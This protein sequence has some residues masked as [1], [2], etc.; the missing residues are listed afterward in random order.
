MSQFTL[1]AT[2]EG[3]RFITAF[4]PGHGAE[5]ANSDHP[6]F[7]QIVALATAGE[8]IDPSL[9]DVAAFVSK[10]FEP[11]SER[12]SV[13]GGRVYLDGDEI[14]NALTRQVVRFLDEGVDDWRPLVAFF[15]NVQA[16]P[17]PHS[18]ENLYRWIAALQEIDGGLTITDEGNIVGYKGVK[19][20]P[21]EQGEEGG[22]VSLNHGYAIVD[23]EEHSEGA[24]PNEV[25]SVI[26]MPRSQVEH[27]PS[28]G[29]SVGLHVGTHAYAKSW[30]SHVLE[31]E[32]NP[33][34]VVS[35]PTDASDQ[36]MRVCRYQ[37]V[38]EVAAPHTTAVRRSPDEEDAYEGDEFE[39]GDLADEDW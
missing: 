26:E 25:G 4:I 5:V 36:K 27:N 29:C 2:A 20:N 1:V 13:R 37:V 16:N 7:D 17:E 15:E 24:V 21:A 8:E 31:V 33:R 38:A 39:E 32:V 12:V 34:D 30:G 3:E 11:L 35:V 6:N 28:R 9:F 10:Q 19:R 23:G 22:Y 18:R 14:D